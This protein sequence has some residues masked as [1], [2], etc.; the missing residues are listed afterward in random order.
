MQLTE[1]VIPCANIKVLASGAI[2]VLQQTVVLR[3]GELESS[4]P[5]KNFRYV[6]MPGDD[7]KDKDPQIVAIAKAVWTPEE[8]A[9]R[10]VFGPVKS[11]IARLS[12]Q[13]VDLQVTADRLEGE[14]N[15]AV[16]E[17]DALRK[18]LNVELARLKP[19][20]GAD[21]PAAGL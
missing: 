6:L 20:K 9:K 14:L 1:Q 11:E 17:R 19:V 15:F 2:E 21:D 13:V 12:R 3:D 18:E 7:L 10:E 5:A 16:A 4:Y 8:I